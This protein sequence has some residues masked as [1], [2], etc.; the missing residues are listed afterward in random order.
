[1]VSPDKEPLRFAG[2]RDFNLDPLSC[3]DPFNPD[4]R[5]VESDIVVLVTAGGS[6]PN[7]CSDPFNPDRG[8]VE[9]DIVV[10]VTGEVSDTLPKKR[11]D[12]SN[13][14]RGV[15]ESD[16]VVPVTGEVCDESPCPEEPA[17]FLSYTRRRCFPATGTSGP[18]YR[19]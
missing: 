10:P 11:S 4:R 16:I 13:P 12:P 5:V 3:S 14:D 9:S 19:G 2:N 17:G 6:F 1:M 8:V 18:A 15:V 7:D